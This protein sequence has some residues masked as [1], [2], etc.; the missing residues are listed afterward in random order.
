[1]KLVCGNTYR[2]QCFWI[3][4]PKPKIGLCFCPE[5]K[6]FFWFNSEPAFHGIGQLAIQQ[7]E[8]PKALQ[9]DC[10]LDLSSV[11][12]AS[13]E[14]LKGCEDR[15]GMPPELAKKILAALS[16]DIKLLPEAQRL[17]AFKNLSSQSANVGRL[18]L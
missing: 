7:N 18:A 1:L 17:L 5:K 15:A 2:Y 9:K 3:D 11:K 8:H 14:E 16:V 10:Y 13:D 12:A 4:P 6:W